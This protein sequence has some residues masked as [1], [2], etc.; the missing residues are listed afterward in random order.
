MI[1]RKCG[2]DFDPGSNMSEQCSECS[3][4][5]RFDESNVPSGQPLSF[6]Q[7]VGGRSYEYS[8]WEDEEQIGFLQGLFLT[9]RQS[10]FQPT[11]FFKRLPLHGGYK[12]PFLYALII[13]TMSILSAYFAT[14]IADSKAMPMAM[15]Q[16]IFFTGMGIGSVI[17]VLLVV[18]LEIFIKPVILFICLLVLGVRNS[19]LEATFRISCYASG[20]G[21]FNIMP[22]YGSI[23]AGIWEFVILVIGLREG[24]KIGTGRAILAILAPII[25]TIILILGVAMLILGRLFSI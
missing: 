18:T 16:G 21:L 3:Q 10:L 1:C 25:A 22:F 24:F 8:P 5:S 15:P 4:S 23:L 9:L 20:P 2:K 19:S 7:N 12:L 13:Y 11:N 14:A 17:Y 6:A